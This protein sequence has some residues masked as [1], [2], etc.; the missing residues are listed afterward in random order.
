MPTVT[1]PL[2]Y[3][4]QL[5]Q[6]PLAQLERQAFDYGLEVTLREDNLEVEVTAER[7]DLLSAE[8]FIRAMNIYGGQPRTVPETL[9]DSGYRVTV[10][11]SVLGLRP[12]LAALVVRQAHL[13]DG[14]L[15]VLIQFQEKVTQTFG[16]QRKK[17]AIGVYDLDR[18]V[19]PLTYTAQ[20]K[21]DVTFVPLG[22]TAP[23]T[24]VNL[25]AHHPAGKLYGSTLPEGDTVPVLR[26]AQGQ[27][28]SLPPIINAAGVGEISADTRNLFIDVTGILDRTVQETI[29]ILAHNFLD[30]GAEVQTV[31]VVTPAGSQ[32]T[33]SLDRRAVSFSA[34]FLNEI[35]GSAIPKA[36]LGQVLGRMDLVVSGTNEVYVPTY[37]TDLISQV[38]LA[39]DLMVAL[40]I[41]SFQPEP[42]SVKFH[43]G[44]ADGLRQFVFRVCD[45]SQRLGLMEVKGHVL[46]DP[47]LLA[48]F[49]EHYLQTSNAK[50]R[51]YS[52]TRTTLQV[53]LLEVL[54]C[55]INAPKPI[56]LYETGEILRL[57]ADGQGEESQSWG[58]ASLNARASFST[59]KAYL[60]T[61]LRALGVTY[62]LTEGH[63]PYYIPGRSA[64]VQMNGQ[65]IG[66][67]GEV[68]PKILNQFS[69][70]EPIAMGELNLSQIY[71]L[72]NTP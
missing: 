4:Q 54:S 30:T 41:D 52:A 32:V 6:T 2:S 20:A 19:G 50:S 44:E 72:I 51:A 35:M 13:R 38:D 56:N 46:T 62:D 7:P 61:L 28:L 15:E 69:F 39:G 5:T 43:L 37:R 58:F 48:L 47:T 12:H 11:P 42:L 27:V 24:A 23:L 17:I 29:N 34:R 14:G 10:D 1:F 53:G 65:T 59:A 26:D 8:G 18:I 40:G 60:Q 70:P 63:S 3:L 25:L 22:E 55:N 68:H 36:K 45:V 71:P 31:T 64:L 16:R 33:P 49:S 67:F 57:A 21:T 9:A 66:E